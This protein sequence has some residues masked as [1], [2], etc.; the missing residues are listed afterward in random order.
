METISVRKEFIMIAHRAACADWKEKIE[1]ELPDL[2][3]K[4]MIGKSMYPVDNSYCINVLTGK[5]YSGVGPAGNCSTLARKVTVISE[6]YQAQINGVMKE[7]VTVLDTSDGTVYRI[8]NN[9]RDKPEPLYDFQ[10]P[11]FGCTSTGFRPY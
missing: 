4:G 9:L 11:S 5:P 8:L 6:P 2:F 3:P 10:I 7:F 1:Q